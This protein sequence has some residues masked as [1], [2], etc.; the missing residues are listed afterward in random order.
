V[1]AV[2]A[3]VSAPRRRTIL[4]RLPSR[5]GWTLL[6]LPLVLFLVGFFGY[7]TAVIVA[8]SFTQ[9]L[10][11]DRGGLDNFRWFFDTPVNI[12]VLERTLIAGF[13]VSAVCLVVGYPYAYLMTLVRRPVRILM[14]SIVVIAGFTSFMVRNYSWL[15]LLQDNGP[16]NN[17]LH[18]LGLGRVQ[19]TGTTT[20][21]YIVYAQILLPLMILP[22]YAT[23]RGIDRRLLKAAS[24][25][26]AGPLTRFR[27]VYLP[28]SI[29]G[30]LAG[31]LLVFVLTLGFYVTPNLIGSPTHAL[32]SQLM[33]IQVSQ[34]LAWGH[35]GAM[36]VV[37]V[38]VT[39]AILGVFALIAR[40]WPMP[41]QEGGA[42]GLAEEDE[43]GRAGAGR[44]ALWIVGVVVSVWL[45][46]PMFIV[47]PQSFA[48]LRTLAFPPPSWGNHWYHNLF[49]DPQWRDTLIRS[50]E[51]AVVVTIVSTVLGTLGALGFV[52]GRFPG[53]TL[54][55]A[56]IALPMIMPLVVFAMGAYALFLQWR[57]TG[58]FFGFVLAHTALA[59]PIVVLLVSAALRTF[60]ER[61]EA[62]AAS[63]GASRLRALATITIPILMPSILV[64]ALFA[65]LTSFDEVLT[66]FF[67]STATVSTLPVQ[68]YNSVLRS[69][70]PTMAAAASVILV[71]TALLMGAV[72][73]AAGRRAR[74]A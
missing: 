22:L 21:V 59:V 70:D 54:V 66:S 15:V 8:R 46:A 34:L 19:F 43:R 13:G 60:D 6:L 26:G 4:S 17:A 64:G 33:T 62:A 11:P 49:A 39:F 74:Y 30:I 23:M 32:F 52:R 5:F 65:F 27:T 31:S 25:L 71:V 51:V 47:F 72:A 40:R 12:T 1:N 10:P 53:K 29:P 73:F 61:L 55:G 2:D 45:I 35:V 3:A 56:L 48:G 18:W 37:L 16:I 20:G 9:F 41:E 28:L 68:M 44:I 63:L 7:P 36:A 42:V 58:T 50:V 69:V 14:I 38:L 57:L 67:I 24:T